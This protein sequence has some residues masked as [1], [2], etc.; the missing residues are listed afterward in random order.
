MFDPVALPLPRLETMGLIRLC[1]L[2]WAYFWMCIE[3]GLVT[4]VCKQIDLDISGKARFDPDWIWACLTLTPSTR[5]HALDR[6]FH[7]AKASDSLGIFKSSLTQH[8]DPPSVTHL[9]PVP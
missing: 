3:F 5:F 2:M 4:M 6:S 8:L 7:I 1:L 9:S